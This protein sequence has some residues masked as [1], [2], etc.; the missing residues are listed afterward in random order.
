MK[1]L[2]AT[3]LILL[4]SVSAFAQENAIPA[5]FH[6]FKDKGSFIEIFRTSSI[7][8]ILVLIAVFLITVIKLVLDARLKRDLVQRD[9]PVE[10]IESLFSRKGKYQNA[11]KIGII[12]VSIGLGLLLVGVFN[13][14]GIYSAAIM[15]LCL[16]VG[17]I[18]YA[19]WVKNLPGE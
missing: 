19:F 9:A 4:A 6:P 15:I 16:S 12:L 1:K 17:F 3:M 8:F 11:V 13:S 18:G 10:I 2:L 5:E 7:I 14:M